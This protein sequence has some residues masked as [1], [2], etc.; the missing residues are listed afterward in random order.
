MAKDYLKAYK[1]VSKFQEGGQM[2][3]QQ[4]A[5][6]QAAPQGGAPDIEGMIM[7]AYESQD[8]NMALQVVNAIAEQMMG[9]QQGGGQPMPAASKGMRLGSKSPR[10]RAGG[11]LV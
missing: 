1:T 2:A 10:F 5:P 6:Q 8:P 7:Q 3:P 9:G 4:A 11:K